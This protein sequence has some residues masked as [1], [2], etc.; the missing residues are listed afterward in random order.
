MKVSKIQKKVKKMLDN[1]RYIHSVSVAYTASCLAMKYKYNIDKAYLAGI[2]HDCAKQLSDSKALDII[3][4]NNIEISDV[5]KNNPFLLH[6][7]V[8]AFIA[9]NKFKIK[10]EDV[11]NA[12][13]YHTTGRPAMSILE[14]I[15]F[16]ADYIEM[17]RKSAINLELI[18]SL[19]FEDIDKCIVKI[20]EDTLKYLKSKNATIDIMTL[21]T[22]EYY[23]ELI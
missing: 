15:I 7:K 5:E 1:K 20:T 19:A 10:D 13:A 8:G 6:G 14:K 9:R 23:K 17:G 3:S 11:I 22:Y 18:R 12:I 4:D 2:L 16:V 21:K